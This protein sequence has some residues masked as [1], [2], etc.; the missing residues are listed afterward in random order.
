MGCQILIVASHT[1]VFFSK[2]PMSST[3]QEGYGSPKIEPPTDVEAWHFCEH[4]VEA[5]VD[6]DR[7]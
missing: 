6:S 3:A 1:T 4:F 7:I 2:K 5:E